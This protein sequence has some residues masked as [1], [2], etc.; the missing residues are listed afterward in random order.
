[1]KV[2]KPALEAADM[3]SRANVGII[4]HL[5]SNSSKISSKFTAFVKNPLS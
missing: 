4:L 3:L 1:M 2:K 5:S